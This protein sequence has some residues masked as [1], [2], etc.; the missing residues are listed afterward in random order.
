MDPAKIE[1]VVIKSTETTSTCDSEKEKVTD[2]IDEDILDS[3]VEST[4]ANDTI[5]LDSSTETSNLN[6]F[7]ISST[8]G[9]L[10]N[11]DSTAEDSAIDT[12]NINIVSESTDTVTKDN[13]EP[14]ETKETTTLD[15]IQ[16]PNEIPK[17]LFTIQSSPYQIVF[18]NPKPTIPKSSAQSSVVTTTSPVYLT[19]K[20]DSD[21]DKMDSKKSSPVKLIT[22]LMEPTTSNANNCNNEI[23]KPIEHTVNLLNNNRILIKSV[24]NSMNANSSN[25]SQPILTQTINSNAN[26]NTNVDKDGKQQMQKISNDEISTDITETNTEHKQSNDETQIQ[27]QLKHHIDDDEVNPKLKLDTMKSNNGEILKIESE[28][29]DVDETKHMLNDTKLDDNSIDEPKAQKIKREFEQLQKDVNHSKVLSEFIFDQNK[30]NRR[31]TKSG[32]KSKHKHST[33]LKLDSSIDE[34]STTMTFR[35]R[36]PSLRTSPSNSVRSASKESD[37][38]ASSS[39]NSSSTGLTGKRNTRSR[40]T[41]FSAKQKQFLKGI[42]QLTRGTDDE[43]DNM[44]DDEADLDFY[45]ERESNTKHQQQQQLQQQVTVSL[46]RRKSIISKAIS[47][48]VE[49]KNVCISFPFLNCLIEKSKSLFI[50]YFCFQK[51]WDKFCWKCHQPQSTI[52]CSLCVRSYHA[53]CIKMKQMTS[54]EMEKWQC[55][56]C[57]EIRAAERENRK[58]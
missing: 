1:F 47:M 13:D 8:S 28:L 41:D 26:I 36:S 14:P 32:G 53:G 57:I 45:L 10:T 25:C 17:P 43:S 52:F 3:T 49:P 54:H 56:E 16:I 19:S 48:N 21:S 46:E 39:F 12:S 22:T 37:R 11:I 23:T 58:K 29:Y 15:A 38:S 35:S 34:K 30:P 55:S 9:N 20:R 27:I 51:A 18:Y 5:A 2:H 4:E 24:K 7:S 31:P 42:Q 33:G 44:D 6:E 40:N 50:D